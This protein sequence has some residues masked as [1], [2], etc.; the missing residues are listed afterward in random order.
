VS[1]VR[2]VLTFNEQLERIAEIGAVTVLGALLSR[3]SILWKDLWF[4][5]V[6]FLGIRPL[7]VMIGLAG[8]GVSAAE[9]RYI[10]WFGIR[11]IGSLYYLMYAIGKGLPEG[12]SERL[13]SITLATMAVSIIVHGIS[14]TP[15]MQLYSKRV[16]GKRPSSRKP[17]TV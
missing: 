6:L 3:Q 14:V 7:A 1:T 13:T 12:L 4:I 9:K 8:S 2:A 16:E 10:S 15:L 5:P 11:G 17:A